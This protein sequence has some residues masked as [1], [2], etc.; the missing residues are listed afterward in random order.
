MSIRR[1]LN[2]TGKQPLLIGLLCAWML[3]GSSSCDRMLVTPDVERWRF[4]IEE[5]EGSVQYAYAQKFKEEIE[6]RS[7]GKIEV[8]IY[9]YGTLGTSKQITEQLS[10]GV[11]E[12]AMA[13]PGS[14]GQFIPE[15]QVFLLHFLLPR[16]DAQVAAILHDSEVMSNIDELYAEKGLK[17]L[18]IY[19]EGDMVWTADREIRSP[20]DFRGVKFR[21]MT[22]PLLLES[23]NAYGAAATPMPYSE[24]YSGLQLNMIDGQVNP[25][26]AIERQKF[27]EVCDW[28]ILPGHAHF[29]TTAA[30][31][32]DFFDTLSPER[33][34]MVQA[35]IH[36]ADEYILGLQVDYQRERLERIL[37]AS[38]AKRA[39]LSISG[40]L[41]SFV[42]SLD[43]KTRKSLVDENPYLEVTPALTR[44]ERATF[45]QLARQ[46]RWD[47]AAEIGDRGQ[48]LLHRLEELSRASSTKPA[49]LEASSGTQD[50]PNRENPR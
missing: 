30:A 36:A 14:I 12:F 49:N 2:F 11:L 19:N 5:L 35:S 26:F 15:L 7:E 25:I 46:V 31:N 40:N 13:S 23:Y 22:T 1:R 4:A 47:F 8:V 34:E 41:Q 29:V 24:V 44:E 33:R 48:A 37:R 9:P 43:E 38:K 16:E 27:Y 3:I 50:Q 45:S 42:E 39:K 28:M 17:L 20:E 21:T 32:R 10:M 18:S 6:S